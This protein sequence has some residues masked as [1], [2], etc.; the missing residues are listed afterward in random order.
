MPAASYVPVRR[1]PRRGRTPYSASLPQ[2]RGAYSITNGTL[3]VTDEI[4]VGIL[5]HGTFAISGG[6]VTTTNF[7]LALS[8]NATAN[9]TITGGSLA[10]TSNITI[11]SAANSAIHLTAG[12]LS[13]SNLALASPTF[14]LLD[15]RYPHR[16]LPMSTST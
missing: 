1:L 15:R 13:V 4:D 11:E 7:V 12:T 3:S 10:V 14:F 2:Q 8:G 9:V 5:G 6:S 16:Q